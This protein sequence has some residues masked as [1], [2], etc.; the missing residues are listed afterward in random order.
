MRTLSPAMN[1]A[2]AVS[3]TQE[4]IAGFGRAAAVA[5]SRPLGSGMHQYAD[6]R[7]SSAK[8][9]NGGRERPNKTLEPSANRANP[10]YPGDKGK[11]TA[12]AVVFAG[13]D[14]AD[15]GMQPNGGDCDKSF[16]LA[17]YGVLKR[18]VSRRRIVGVDNG[19]VLMADPPDGG[20][21]VFTLPVRRKRLR[22]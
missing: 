13:S 9:P 11:R 8:V 7:P 4:D 20:G 21:A 1:F 10:V 12:A 17:G 2:R 19:C 15:D 14:T 16:A 3:A 22:M 18:G 5:S 6:A